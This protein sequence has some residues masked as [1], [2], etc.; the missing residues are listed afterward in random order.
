[1][2]AD[3]LA[4]G[5]DPDSPFHAGEQAVQQR[6]G[7]RDKIEQFG[8]RMFRDHMPDQHRE[9][10][11][12]L[13]MLLVGSVDPAGR[14]WASMLVGV[15]GFIS[16]PNDSLLRVAALPA[17]VD[18]LHAQLAVGAA[19]GVLGIEPHTRRRNRVNGHVAHVGSDDFSLRVD[20]SFGN[21]PKYIQARMPHW[22][23]E[24]SALSRAQA[25]ERQA[26]TLAPAA[27]RLVQSADTFYIASS[28]AR[29]GAD[30]PADGVD[31]SHRG[32]KPGFV[33]L[34][35]ENGRSVLTIPDFVGNFMFNTLGNLVA[36][37]LA[38]L[39]FTD[40]DNGDLLQLTGRAEIVWDGPQVQVFDGA[41]RLLRIIVDEALWRPGAVP[42]RWSAP[43]LSPHVAETGEWPD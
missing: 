24:P 18:P 27:R 41:Q 40:P 14:P 37:P 7:V 31:V 28:V 17:P 16:T 38:G 11:A 33:H 20:Q 1:M 19:L 6:V 32:G 43:Q 26:Q 36:H 10:F 5:S 21:C 2:S 12:Q 4:K 13:P 8:R 15:P 34:G 9:L 42:L 30:H 3:E 23:A 25:V 35:D 22:V 29:I 39:L